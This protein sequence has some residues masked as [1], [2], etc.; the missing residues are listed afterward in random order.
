M[1][2]KTRI[3]RR[4]GVIPAEIYGH[5]IENEHVSIL[6]KEFSKI[7]KAAGEN[8][9]VNLIT[10]NQGKIP[11]LISE[12]NHDA[13]SGQILNVDFHQVRMDEKIQTKVPLEFTGV[14]PATKNDLVI[15]TVLTDLEIEALPDK[16]PHRIEVSLNTLEKAGESIRVSDLKI[17]QDV[18][19]LTS[20]ETAI[21]TVSAKTK[22]EIEIKPETPESQEETSA[23]TEPEIETEKTS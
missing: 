9:I 2:K 3:L 14:A 17:S 16:I 10:E 5:G 4:G 22:E 1:G 23:T 18:K 7:Y 11:V 12:V 19:I 8:T 21:V 15:V 13:L 20:L 6:E